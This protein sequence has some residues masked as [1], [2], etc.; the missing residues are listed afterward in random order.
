MHS[1]TGELAAYKFALDE[2]A[3]VAVTDRLGHIIDVNDHFC[4]SSKFSREELIGQKQSIVNSDHH[5]KKFHSD[6]WQIIAAG[7][8]WKGEIRNLAKDGSLYWVHTTIVPRFDQTGAIAG[9][10]SI[11]FDI[12]T[13]KEIERSLLIESRRRR[14]AETLLLELIEA[15]PSGVAAYDADDRLVL[16]NSTYRNFIPTADC[17]SP[18]QFTFEEIIRS[19]VETGVF[20]LREGGSPEEHEAGIR[21]NLHRHRESGK[22]STHKLA[23]GRWF[24]AQGRKASTGHIVEVVT[25]ITVV[26]EAES[27]IR[28]QVR[29]DPLTGI[30]NRIGLEAD[31]AKAIYDYEKTGACFGLA[32][33]D[34]DHFKQVN[35]RFGHDAGDTVLQ[36]IAKRLSKLDHIRSVARTGGDEFAIIINIS[37]MEKSMLGDI[38]ETARQYVF[39][40]ILYHNKSIDLSGSVGVAAYPDDSGDSELL[41]RAADAALLVAKRGGRGRVQ[42]VNAAIQTASARRMLIETSLPGAIAQMQIVPAYQ[43]IVTAGEHALK[44]MEVLARWHHPELGPISPDEFIPIAQDCGLLADLDKM[45]MEQACEEARGWLES[46]TIDCLSLNASPPDIIA[47]GFATGLLATLHRLKIPPA[48]ICLEIFESSIVEDFRMARRNL[49]RLSEAGVKIA[50][51]DFGTG[52]SN[53]QNT[54]ELPINGLKLDRSLIQNRKQSKLLARIV[55]GLASISRDFEIYTVAEGVETHEDMA[56]A[57]KAGCQFLQ[58]FFFSKPMPFRDADAYVRRKG[59]RNTL[60]PGANWVA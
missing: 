60:K 41:K 27:R 33:L 13:R 56:F 20:A 19:A 45:M 23:D 47:R 52:F 6:I 49:F 42:I 7:K 57:E 59:L 51:D 10:V 53:L 46:G 32:F 43:P 36:V 50:I 4:A 29:I 1:E 35:D 39:R 44:G 9:F 8:S 5:P 26:K 54:L 58:G 14:D 48:Q 16:C 40:P 22:P 18:V 21:E 12:T 28:K 34:V 17:D 38:A 25:D 11:G 30:F 15:M 3:I 55:R 31:L 2:H 24:Q 37:E